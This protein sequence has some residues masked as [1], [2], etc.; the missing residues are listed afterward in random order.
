VRALIEHRLIQRETLE[1][2][3]TATELDAARRELAANL[4]AEMFGRL[5]D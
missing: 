2:R 1:K 5:R 3:L 4:V